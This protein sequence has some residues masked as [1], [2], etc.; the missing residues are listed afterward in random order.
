MSAIA[1]VRVGYD[2]PETALAPLIAIVEAKLH[3]A[4]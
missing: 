1:A 3:G 2:T 4:V